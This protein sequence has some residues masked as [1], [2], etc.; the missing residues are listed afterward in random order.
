MTDCEISLFV[1]VIVAILVAATDGW[2]AVGYFKDR[3]S[4]GSMVGTS[5]PPGA[6]ALHQPFTGYVVGDDF[7]QTRED[8]QK[9]IPVNNE[10]EGSIRALGS[11]ETA[12]SSS[13]LKRK[14]DVVLGAK[15]DH[16]NDDMEVDHQELNDEDD[17][18]FL[19]AETYLQYSIV[20][21]GTGLVGSH[22]GYGTSRPPLL[23][24]ND[25]LEFT[26]PPNAPYGQNGK[27]LSF[28]DLLRVQQA[29]GQRRP[30]TKEE[31][32][33]IFD[34]IFK[35]EQ[36]YLKQTSEIFRQGLTNK[37]A[38]EEATKIRRGSSYQ[39]DLRTEISKL[40]IQ[41][42][43]FERMLG[44][45]ARIKTERLLHNNELVE[46]EFKFKPDRNLQIILSGDEQKKEWRVQE[47]ETFELPWEYP[48][49]DQ[50][51]EWLLIEDPSTGKNF[52]WSSVTGE[53]KV[54]FDA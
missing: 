54:D 7:D 31:E 37:T 43:E 13:F 10:K 49:Q 45:G 15:V 25:F 39:K 8:L 48:E 6:L 1:L 34:D 29:T 42:D 18:I 40:E 41:L 2:F 11:I 21:K 4:T 5:T 17:S 28:E 51:E 44:D 52:S 35:D 47:E 22:D 36:V 16:N 9:D 30:P 50:P 24:E 23:S 32:K 46:I 38:A 3:L 20:E 19:D 26:M 27:G 12:R 53:M 33:K 14:I